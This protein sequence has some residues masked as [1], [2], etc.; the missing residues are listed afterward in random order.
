MTAPVKAGER[1]TDLALPYRTQLYGTALRL[2]GNWADAEDLVQETYLRA[3]AGFGTFE[4]GTNLRAWLYRIETN[5]FC[6]AYRARQRHPHEI[7]ADSVSE[8][9]MSQA[10]RVLSAEEAALIRMP[11]TMILEALRGLP[12]EQMVTVYLADAE[13]YQYAEIAERTGVPL[14]TV[15][16]RLHRGRKR[17]RSRLA[18]HE[19]KPRRGPADSRRRTTHGTGR[20]AVLATACPP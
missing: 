7:P 14:G 8:T 11:D 10:M 12:D 9:V 4:P 15:M 2:T 20:P 5:V 18:G 6:S 16:S 13:G 3:Y 17:L 19:R 1:F